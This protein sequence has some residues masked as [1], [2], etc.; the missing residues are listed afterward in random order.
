MHGCPA[1]CTIAFSEDPPGSGDAWVTVRGPGVGA[2]GAQRA[3]RRW[4]TLRGCLRTVLVPD[5]VAGVRA[6]LAVALPTHPEDTAVGNVRWGV[7][8]PVWGRVMVSVTGPDP[9]A[10]AAF[11][12]VV[13]AALPAASTDAAAVATCV[14]KGCPQVVCSG[15]AG[16]PAGPCGHPDHPGME[17]PF[18][19]CV[20]GQVAGP[21]S[22]HAPTITM[23]G[24]MC[25]VGV[26]WVL[27]CVPLRGW[28]A[29]RVGHCWECG[30]GGL[31]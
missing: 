23:K 24:A 8:G 17:A 29:G 3:I 20:L 10:V 11:V 12:G 7:E 26:M 22:A 19:R 28:Q 18:L 5:S 25:C 9:G 14:Y 30:G 27:C 1:R 2:T 6:S 31:G 4:L 16:V 13:K 21:D 15:G